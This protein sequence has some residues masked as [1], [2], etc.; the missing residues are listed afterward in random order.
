MKKLITVAIVSVLFLSACNTNPAENEF[1]NKG[2]DH[3]QNNEYSL[4]L[5]QFRLAIDS[6]NGHSESY[7]E[8]ADILIDKGQY[9]DA[10][11]LLDGGKDHAREKPGIY[12][13]LAEVSFITGDLDKA[14][15][16][17][18]QALKLD[19]ES[20]TAML[21][22]INVLS[23]QG[24]TDALLSFVKNL[25]T[26]SLD[27]ELKIVKGLVLLE[28]RSLAI[29]MFD[30]AA[31]GSNES[32][33]TIAER[34]SKL[35]ELLES[36]PDNELFNLAKIAFA[37]L[38]SGW[39]AVAFPI[40][41]L[42]V[43]SNEFYEGS[44]TYRGVI[45]LNLFNFDEAIT[46]LKQAVK[47]SPDDS[48]IKILLAQAYFHAGEWESARSTLN[49]IKSSPKETIANIS[50]ILNLL[51]EFERYNQANTFINRYVNTGGEVTPEFQILQLE[52]YLGIEN[53]EKSQVVAEKLLDDIDQLAPE[54]QA[55]AYTLIAFSTFKAGNKADGQ[56]MLTKAQSL[57]ST[58]PLSYLYEGM[59]DLDQ[60]NYDDAKAA[61]SR[62]VDLDFEGNV[63]ARASAL[64]A[65][66]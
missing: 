14:L 65:Q 16:Y 35:T 49:R 40:T 44:Y 22:K 19:P 62:A 5:E 32:L 51:L 53:F 59:I 33:I 64:L 2:L 60:E 41:N 29:D 48:S 28:E 36:D 25:N 23:L 37:A 18:N 30:Q 50:Q 17:Y 43:D 1:Y 61:F 46:N 8:A 66:L 45:Y 13:R 21:G 54:R 15:E 39:F 20:R 24:K 52:V 31:T 7:I 63:S 55:R 11:S 6:D 27:Q 12:E 26:G 10:V 58:D 57:D 38:D 3:L 56:D 42:M 34:L 4:A 9:D 47:L